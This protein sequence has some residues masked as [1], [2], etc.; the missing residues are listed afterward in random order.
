MVLLCVCATSPHALGQQPK[1]EYER[2]QSKRTLELKRLNKPLLTPEIFSGFKSIER[3]YKNLL[4]AGTNGRNQKELT[5]LRDGLAYRILT[6]SDGDIQADS[7]RF[8]TANTTLSRELAGAG[9]PAQVPNA[10]QRQAFR[11]LVYRESMPFVMKLLNEG[12]FLSRSAAIQ[13]LLD[14]ESVPARGGA[15]MR[16][17]DDVHKAYIAVLMDPEQPDSL[18]VIAASAIKV[19][20]QK[21]DAVSTIELALAEAMVAELDRPHLSIAYQINLLQALEEIRAPRQVAGKKEPLIY[22]TMAN[23]ITDRAKDIQVRC[24]AARVMGRTGWDR[25]IDF[26]VLAWA[27]ADLTTETALLF[28]QAA[29]K[30]APK[31]H[32]C[33]WSLYTAFHHEN[34]KEVDGSGPEGMPK[35]FLNRAPQSK[36]VRDAYTNGVA[37]MA[38]L[39]FNSK[40]VAARDVGPLF[41]WTTQ[42]KPANLVFDPTCPPLKPAAKPAGN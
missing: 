1:E 37:V 40:P 35:G 33:G 27:A 39:M 10:Q 18:K 7:R 30:K 23:L 6:L 26:D 8:S 14:M 31:W 22:C 19:Y 15:R 16:M 28:N 36:I 41:K 4:R 9:N 24:R 3:E 11:E 21:A 29:N 12:N 34:K 17:F 42:N 5:M 38:H 25:Q 20:L 32:R 13:R 2:A